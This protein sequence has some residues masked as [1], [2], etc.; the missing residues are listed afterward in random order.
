[1]D[2][3]FPSIFRD[4]NDNQPDVTPSMEDLPDLLRIDTL[5]KV[6]LSTPSGVDTVT[7]TLAHLDRAQDWLHRLSRTFQLRSDHL[8][9]YRNSQMNGGLPIARLPVEVL[10]IIF[11][12]DAASHGL[13]TSE[14]GESWM[15]LGAVCRHWRLVLFDTSNI[16][17][18]DLFGLGISAV[19]DLLPFTKNA[20]LNIILPYSPPLDHIEGIYKMMTRAWHFSGEIPLQEDLRNVID[21]LARK[22]F[23]YLESLRLEFEYEDNRTQ[24][25][26]SRIKPMA[27]CPNLKHLSLANFYMTPPVPNQLVSLAIHFE[28]KGDN[29]RH[30]ATE[31]PTLDMM[32]EVLSGNPTLCD[33]LLYNSCTKAPRPISS[34]KRILLPNLT[35]INLHHPGALSSNLL[36]HLWLP[37]LDDATLSWETPGLGHDD[38]HDEGTQVYKS[39]LYAWAQPS[40][41]PMEKTLILPVEGHACRDMHARQEQ[42][43]LALKDVNGALKGGYQIRRESTM[44]E[45]VQVLPYNYVFRREIQS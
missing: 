5:S 41:D 16:W 37:A 26:K 35:S 13:W 3:A 21:I 34:L 24:Q 30:S 20:P 12:Y 1:M 23:P 27:N 43:S 36:D 4:T 40:T 10:R 8:T 42:F 9:A 7:N 44:S 15:R 45:G 2:L 25:R 6:T 31:K 28:K 18:D 14:F 22:S 11:E 39:L 38:G 29:S 19:S 17:A 33:L 32:V